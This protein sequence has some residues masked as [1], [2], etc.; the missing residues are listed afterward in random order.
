M[1]L[2]YQSRQVESIKIFLNNANIP[3]YNTTV[4]FKSKINVSFACVL[5][6]K[7]SMLK[8]ETKQFNLNN[9]V[10]KK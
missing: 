3:G 5:I 7:R 4:H 6:K 9:E 1:S 8:E 2:Q 10:L